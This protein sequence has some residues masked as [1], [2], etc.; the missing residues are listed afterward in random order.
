MRTEVDNIFDAILILEDFFA[1]PFQL[2]ESA[3]VSE[4]FKKH[5]IEAGTEEEKTWFAFDAKELLKKANHYR[6]ILKH[7]SENYEKYDNLN[8]VQ[9]NDVKFTTDKFF[10][11][12]VS[13]IRKKALKSLNQ[14]DRMLA[15]TK[16]DEDRNILLQVKNLIVQ[17]TNSL[18]DI[19]V[20]IIEFNKTGLLSHLQSLNVDFKQKYNLAYL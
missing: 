15:A 2:E 8:S 16:N 5:L 7:Y 12:V 14:L 11:Q 20:R 4:Y 1:L 9:E 17:E 13:P 18:I 6:V 3:L 19:C 10:T